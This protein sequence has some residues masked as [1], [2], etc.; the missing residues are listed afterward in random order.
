MLLAASTKVASAWHIIF[1]LV[2]TMTATVMV[3]FV[4]DW[5]G[6]WSRFWSRS[7]FRSR[8]SRWDQSWIRQ[9]SR[10]CRETTKRGQTLSF[11]CIQDHTVKPVGSRYDVLQTSNQI[12]AL[13]LVDVNNQ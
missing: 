9:L 13:R 8:I 12:V 2:T 6:C 3:F 4:F 7:W 10:H 5:S 1:R 11:R